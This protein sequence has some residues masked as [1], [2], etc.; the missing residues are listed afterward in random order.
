MT[1]PADSQGLIKQAGGNGN[2][3]VASYFKNCSL[4]VTSVV[5]FDKG[6]V[7]V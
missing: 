7:M 5:H 3:T 4:I 2:G 1:S 6:V